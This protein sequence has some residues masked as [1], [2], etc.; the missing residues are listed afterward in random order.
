MQ[1]LRSDGSDGYDVGSGGGGEV[2][3]AEEVATCRHLQ[4]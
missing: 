4:R 2:V 1:Y 3:E